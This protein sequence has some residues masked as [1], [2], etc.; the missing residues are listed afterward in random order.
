MRSGWFLA[1]AAA[2][3]LGAAAVAQ[4]QDGEEGKKVGARPSAASVEDLIRDLASDDFNVRE[5]AT[6]ELGRRGEAAIPALERAA[7]D[8][9][10]EVRWRAEKAL[11]EARARAAAGPGGGAGAGRKPLESD[12]GER[13]RERSTPDAED[14]PRDRMSEQ[15]RSIEEQMRRLAPR[16]QEELPRLR[17]AI[18]KEFLKMLEEIEERLRDLDR[19]IPERPPVRDF[20]SFRYKNGRWQIERSSDPVAEKV[21][22]RTQPVPPVARAQLELAETGLAIEEVKP[23]SPAAKAGILRYDI[24]LS[25]DGKPTETDHDLEILARPGEHAVLLLRGGERQTLRFVTE[26]A[27]EADGEGEP[28]GAA[29][30]PR[31]REG[32]GLRK[33]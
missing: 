27:S 33:Y 30:A 6:E 25:V 31:E 16:I 1:A 12:A 7:K 24:V 10:P 20:W 3:L 11:K 19:P 17:E 26:G 22:V 4:A 9:D 29:P 15:L 14:A 18:P 2:L 13:S 23:G 21:G 32:G 8:A 28:R 5:S